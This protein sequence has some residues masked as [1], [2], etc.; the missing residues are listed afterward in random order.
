MSLF[1]KCRNFTAAKEVEKA[2]Y[3]PYFRAISSGS[4]NEVIIE[5]RKVIMIGSNNYLGLTNHPKV[6]ERIHQ[7]VDKYGSSCTGSRFLNGTL[8]I[9]V[10]LEE[11]LAQFMQTEAALVYSTGF[12]TNLGAIS[13]I[14]GKS[15]YIL[16]DRSDHASIV[17]GCR[18]SFGHTIKYKH[19]DMDDLERVLRKIPKEAGKL[20]VTDGV[21]SMEGDIVN[22]PRLVELAGIYDAQILVDDA[23]SIGVLGEHGRGTA[24]HFHLQDKVDMVMG[25]FSKSF[26]SIGGYIAASEDVIHYIKHFSRPLIFSASPPPAAV[27]AVLASLEIIENEPERRIRLWEITNRMHREYKAMG[28]N[29][30]TT[31]TPI[32]PI[33]IGD[34][35]K[36]FMFWKELTDA[37]L[38]TNPIV[39]PAVPPGQALIRT[40]YTANHTDEQMDRVLDIFYKVGKKLGII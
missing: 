18:L 29:L 24:E 27:A 6:I 13:T 7:A 26:A 33:Y 40:S 16:A 25:T 15:D 10:E 23:H 22:L 11:K 5:G 21:F 12:Q 28:F 19:N 1:K 39:S 3:Y 2:G 32:I 37:G 36:T 14:V 8:D 38:F 30:G 34:D 31:Q 20:I 17:D 35:Q 4:D 9:H